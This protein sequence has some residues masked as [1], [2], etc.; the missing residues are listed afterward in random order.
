M[1]LINEERSSLEEVIQTLE[2]QKSGSSWAEATNHWSVAYAQTLNGHNGDAW[3]KGLLSESDFQSIQM[4]AHGHGQ[5][6]EIFFKLG[7]TA[8]KAKEYFKDVRSPV[9]QECFNL[10]LSLK[11]KIKKEGFTST[12]AL[13]VQNGIPG[14]LDGVHRILALSM[15][16]DEGVEYKPIPVFTWDPGH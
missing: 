7:T 11:E 8:N 15:L 13:A 5:G 16:L 1:K 14:H 6:D 4:P 2:K 10:I 12:I 3:Y 9:G